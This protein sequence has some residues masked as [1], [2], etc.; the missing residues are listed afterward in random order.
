MNIQLNE[1]GKKLINQ[2]K[3][4]EE[5]QKKFNKTV[6][7]MYQKGEF[8]YMSQLLAADSFGEFLN[9]FESL[10]LVVK[11]DNAVVKDYRKELD[12][13]QKT[14]DQIEKLKKEK[15]PKLKEAEKKLKTLTGKI[16][17]TS[18]QFNALAQKEEATKEDLDKIKNLSSTGSGSYS[19]G[20]FAYPT[21]RNGRVSSPFWENRGG[22]YHK[23]IDI[24]RPV[25]TPI[26]AAAAGKV[27]DSGPA[28]GFGNWI[29]VDH[30]NGLK[31]VY[32]HMYSWGVYVHTGQKVAKGQKIGAVGDDGESEG[33]HLHFEVHK[34]GVPVNPN[35]YF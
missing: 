8:G 14:Q 4:V 9:R 35:N 15:E 2:K 32:G 16:K 29:V 17:D 5:K 27:I 31:T 6:K 11:E 25:G 7:R 33:A 19:G 22:Y 3:Q 34:N 24:P 20:K 13:I 1:H 21:T 28:T 10:R 26:F 23:G 18:S 12:K 30:G